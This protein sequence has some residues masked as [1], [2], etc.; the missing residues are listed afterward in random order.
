MSEPPR[1]PR[2][3]PIQVFRVGPMTTTYLMVRV[4]SSGAP[5][6]WTW[7]WSKVDFSGVV[8]DGAKV[9]ALVYGGVDP[10]D[11]RRVVTFRPHA[12]EMD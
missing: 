1:M 10:E 12:H 7:D 4:T 2:K 6:A 3:P 9:T 8:P 5:D 11:N